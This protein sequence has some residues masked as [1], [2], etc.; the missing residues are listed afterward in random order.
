MNRLERHRRQRPR[1]LRPHQRA[2]G[3]HPD[4]RL[5]ILADDRLQA[6]HDP[7]IH[8]RIVIQKRLDHLHR[9]MRT[10]STML[11][12]RSSSITPIGSVFEVSGYGQKYKSRCTRTWFRFVRWPENRALA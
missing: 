7:L 1:D 6:R 4:Q 9:M 2:I 12:N 3:R 5:R 11:W 8:Q 10:W